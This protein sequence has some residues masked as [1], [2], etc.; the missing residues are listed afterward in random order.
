M[1]REGHVLLNG[2]GLLPV[3]KDQNSAEIRAC[4]YAAFRVLFGTELQVELHP[5]PQELHQVPKGQIAET[6]GV[7]HWPACDFKEAA[8]RKEDS[9][10]VIGSDRVCDFVKGVR[11]GG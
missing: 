10:V 2:Q 4:S 6:E 11:V 1:G 5:L 8:G 7:R 9:N 3:L